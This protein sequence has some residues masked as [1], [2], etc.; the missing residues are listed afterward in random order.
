M[1]L[2][3]EC[4]FKRLGKPV[5]EE[6]SPD[7]ERASAALDDAFWVIAAYGHPCWTPEKHPKVIRTLALV[8]AER[9]F[10]NPE[11]YVQEQ[12]GEVSYRMSDGTPMG[13]S[14]T[15]GEQALIDRVSGRGGLK[16]VRATRD[17]VS[18]GMQVGYPYP[19]PEGPWGAA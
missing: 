5:P 3:V 12:V 9:R 10:R 14:L 8:V 4:L 19:N 2:T 13:L 7:W 18:R 1:A 16:S 15:R 17:V 11:G 6:G